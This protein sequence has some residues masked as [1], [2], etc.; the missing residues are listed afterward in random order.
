MKG[1]DESL[2]LVSS[3]SVVKILGNNLVAKLAQTVLSE[4]R[5]TLRS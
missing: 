1:H 5:T 2:L 4:Q 3:A